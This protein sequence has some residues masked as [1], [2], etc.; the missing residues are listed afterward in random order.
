MTRCCWNYLFWS[1]SSEN[2]GIISG[3]IER[4]QI[5]CWYLTTSTKQSVLFLLFRSL[6]ILCNTYLLSCVV[7]V[8]PCNGV[9]YMCVLVDSI[10]PFEYFFKICCC[11]VLI[12]CTLG[13][14]CIFV[15][16]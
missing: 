8:N 14:V 2:N 7:F 13:D 4:F 9:R 1:S 16:I 6:Y 5:V 15:L 12:I 10:V 11:C 3:N